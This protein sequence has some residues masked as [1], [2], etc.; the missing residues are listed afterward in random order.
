MAPV[1]PHIRW[2]FGL[3]PAAGL[4]VVDQDT[5]QDVQQCV[6]VLLH[7]P[8]GSRPL[9]PHIGTDDNTFRADYPAGAVAREVSEWEPRAVVGITPTTSTDGQVI[10]VSVH[11]TL[12][13]G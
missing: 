2:P 5:I 13:G 11:T 9:A 6:H 7:T 10:R 8:R 1:I 3:S 12:K 4:A